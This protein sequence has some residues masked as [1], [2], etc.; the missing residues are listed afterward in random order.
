MKYYL[1]DDK[2]SLRWVHLWS[3]NQFDDM[4]VRY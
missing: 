4:L 3:H 2:L 1:W